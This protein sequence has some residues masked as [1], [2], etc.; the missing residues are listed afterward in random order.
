M[1]ALRQTTVIPVEDPSQVAVARRCAMELGVRAGLDATQAGKL[2]IAV[3]ELAN[4]LHRY[5]RKGALL[6]NAFD[7][8]HIL[9]ILAID[10]GPGMANPAECLRDGYT[11]GST[12]GLGLG[13]VKRLSQQMDIYSQLDKGTVISARFSANGDDLGEADHELTPPGVICSA[14]KGEDFCGD[15]WADRWVEDKHL[16]ILVDGLG[17]GLYASQAAELAIEVFLGSK[18]ASPTEIVDS[19]HVALRSTR[20]AAALILA[21]DPARRRITSCGIGNISASLHRDAGPTQHIVSHNGTIGHQIRKVAGFEYDYDPGD[22]L[23]MH[24]DGLSARWSLADYPQLRATSP[25]CIAGVL[26]RD[27]SRDRDDATVL[28]TRLG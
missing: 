10:H 21:V 16:Y 13:A 9:E 17:H 19:M 18:T 23:I 15:R 7:D 26:Y 8:R 25:S 20:G 5:A 24:S 3:V 1:D 14:L 12:P 27:H 4:N 22:V 6:I 2:E 28:V 11:T